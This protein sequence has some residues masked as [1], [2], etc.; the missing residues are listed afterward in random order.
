MKL[1]NLTMV[2]IRVVKKKYTVGCVRDAAA[3]FKRR[4]RYNVKWRN[5]SHLYYWN[6]YGQKYF[7]V[8]FLL[9]FF[10]IFFLWH[11][12][13]VMHE[14]N[15]IPKKTKSVIV[16]HFHQGARKLWRFEVGNF[17]KI[18]KNPNNFWFKK[19]CKIFIEHT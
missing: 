11:I 8:T 17:K 18:L 10:L 15:V 6:V 19:K 4:I 1:T 7:F 9:F 13:I 14:Y 2:Y 16:H 5:R 12:N 3:K